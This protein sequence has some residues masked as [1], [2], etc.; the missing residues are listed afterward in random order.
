MTI[1]RARLA[2]RAPGQPWDKPDHD[3][4]ESGAFGGRPRFQA[5]YP[6]LGVFADRTLKRLL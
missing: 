3:D 1:E 5:L 4:R 6:R 2:G